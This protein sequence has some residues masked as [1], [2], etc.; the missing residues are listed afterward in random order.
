MTTDY[1]KEGTMAIEARNLAHVLVP[2]DDV[3]A[4]RK[5]Y[6]DILGLD[7]ITPPATGYSFDLA[8]FERD[9][10]EIHIVRRDMAVEGFSED[11]N[12]SLQPHVAF[13][14]A[15]IEAAREQLDANGYQ[16][17]EANGAGVLSRL[18]IF[19]RDPSGFVVELFQRKPDE[20]EAQ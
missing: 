11:F 16:Y 2:T 8:W 10:S 3:E 15:D 18:Q 4:S 14:V 7:A 1:R 12:P 6:G 5:F 13:E 17:H 19:V 20:A 9:G